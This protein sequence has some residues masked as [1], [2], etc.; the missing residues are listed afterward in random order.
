MSTAASPY[1]SVFNRTLFSVLMERVER[2]CTA[3]DELLD[4]F[5]KRA[6]MPVSRMRDAYENGNQWVA[7]VLFGLIA[8]LDWK[9][10]IV[11]E[12]DNARVPVAIPLRPVLDQAIAE[13]KARLE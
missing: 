8:Q 1:E 10:E 4:D 11:V 5:E 7:S 13:R 9:L 6:G 2:E 12:T 3:D